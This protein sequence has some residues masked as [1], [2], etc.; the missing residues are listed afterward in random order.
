MKASDIMTLG[1][2][3]V[4]QDASLL[5]AI[6]AMVSHRISAL[7]VVDDKER[8]CGILTEGDIVRAVDMLPAAALDIPEAARKHALSTNKVGTYMTGGVI[9]V[10]PDVEVGDAVALMKERSLKR[11]PVVSNG[12][13]LG[14]LSRADLLNALVA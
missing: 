13:V 1:A 5:K 14:L 7:P 10:G 8:L 9:T 2:A 12:K 3:T 11:L 6:E 4:R